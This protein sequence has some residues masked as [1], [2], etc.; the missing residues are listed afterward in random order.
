MQREKI[1]LQRRLVRRGLSTLYERIRKEQLIN[2]FE[3]AKDDLED[4]LKIFVRMNSGA[5]ILS[6]T[7]LLFS[8]IVATWNDGREQIENLLKE[9]NGK[10][11]GFSFGNEYLMRCCLV[12]SDGPVVFK[13]N[14]FKSE[15][16]QKIRDEWP[17]IAEA[18][19]K[20]VD[21]LVEFGFSGSV[22]T[23]EISTI[24]IAYYIHQGG[25]LNKES[26]KGI[27]K[28]LTHHRKSPGYAGV[29]VEV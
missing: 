16:V 26:K 8:T 20:T 2:Y 25:E 29:A 14:S 10:G 5:T 3:V 28:Y 1:L 4:I 21:L 6:K 19:K 24:I 7:D 9:I 15:N 18:V 17:L 13:V 12:L 27:Q 22:L 23:S 11:D